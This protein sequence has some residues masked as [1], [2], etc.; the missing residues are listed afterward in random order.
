MKTVIKTRI[1]LP[2]ASLLLLILPLL[3]HLPLSA[4]GLPSAGLLPPSLHNPTEASALPSSKTLSPESS[5][6]PQA[7]DRP[8]LTA[9]DDGS[10]GGE[11]DLPGG[12]NTDGNSNV[13]DGVP[14]ADAVWLP[15]LL[16]ILYAFGTRFRTR[17]TQITR[18]N[19]N[20][21]NKRICADLRHLC[22]L[23]SPF[24]ERASGTDS[25]SRRDNMLVERNIHTI[26]P[27]V[28]SGTECAGGDNVRFSHSHS[29]PYGTVGIPANDIFYQ[30]SVPNGTALYCLNRDFHD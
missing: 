30:H 14:V 23:R 3:S 7:T 13:V 2:A 10:G 6:L 26:S 22:H 15:I 4:Q 27:T 17:M 20:L 8:V 29:V 11:D 1:I 16:A 18:M 24:G 12:G 28:P 21:Y 5:L 19:A 25:L 9:W